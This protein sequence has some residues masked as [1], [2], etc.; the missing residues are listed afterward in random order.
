[1]T[2]ELQQTIA[3]LREQLHGVDELSQSD[4]DSLQC[5]IDEIQ[6]SLEND[7][8]NSAGLAVNL[9]ESTQTFADA[10]PQLTRAAGQVA[11]MLSQMGI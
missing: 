1:M 4:R 3:Q 6:Q 11:D 7:D 9:H 10:H 2:K 5:A 8:V